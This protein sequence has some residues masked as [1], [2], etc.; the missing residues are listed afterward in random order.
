MGVIIAVAVVGLI[1]I[2]ILL[3]ICSKFFTLNLILLV[4]AGVG[5]IVSSF[6]MPEFKNGID[7][8]WAIPQALFIFLYVVMLSASIAFD[9]EDYVSTT[10]T[11]HYDGSVTA[12]SRLESRSL[13]WGVIGT[14]LGTAALLVFLNYIIFETHAIA[15]GVIGCLATAWAAFYLIK[16]TVLR[17]RAKHG[18]SY[19]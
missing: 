7:W 19:Y 8:N 18:R 13:F 14:G 3:K 6:S 10:V 15:L 11:E 5:L 9:K 2:T 12:S 16:Y 17:F 4:A 1:L